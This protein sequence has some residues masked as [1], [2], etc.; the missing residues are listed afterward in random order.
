MPLPDA[1]L[2]LQPLVDRRTIIL[3]KEFDGTLFFMLSWA[4]ES[5]RDLG[6]TAPIVIRC[7]GHGGDISD[8]MACIDLI[9]MQSANIPIHAYLYGDNASAHSVF[10]AACPVRF[11]MPR[12]TLSIHSAMNW[13]AGY[14]GQRV[15]QQTVE[16]IKDTNNVMADLYA[17]ACTNKFYDVKY[18]LKV[19]SDRSPDCL[20]LN[21]REIA[22][23]YRMGTLYKA[24]SPVESK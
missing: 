11:I 6:E 9:K 12:A 7:K 24:K 3:P 5:I 10:W 13:G 21:A 16:D 17:E 18:W 23:T 22:K 2:T 1:L 4:I 8:L 14:Q 15:L 20:T 19:L